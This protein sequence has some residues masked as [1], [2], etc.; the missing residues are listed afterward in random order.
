[1]FYLF[2]Y[3]YSAVGEAANVMLNAT[4]K[5]AIA[6]HSVSIV[7]GKDTTV[8]INGDDSVIAEAV[9]KEVLY[10]AYNNL[11]S[12][13]G[14]SALWN[15]VISS[16]GTNKAIPNIMV[17]KES[18]VVLEPN[19][20]AFPATHIIFYEKGAKSGALSEEEAVKR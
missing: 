17:D 13:K 5:D 4:Y 18:A 7:N 16:T 10:G 15:G 11:L 9:S 8:I 20:L 6:I 19:N 14:V 3:C 2:F 1:M 12:L